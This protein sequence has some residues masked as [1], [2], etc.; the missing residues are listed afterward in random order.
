[1]PAVQNMCPPDI[2]FQQDGASPHDARQVREFL[3]DVF[4]DAWIGRRSSNEWPAKSCDMTP[5]D[6]SVWGISRD[7]VYLNGPKP[8]IQTLKDYV[9]DVPDLV[10]VPVLLFLDAKKLQHET[11]TSFIFSI[12]FPR[13]KCCIA[14]TIHNPKEQRRNNRQDV[15]KFQLHPF[16]AVSAVFGQYGDR[17]RYL[18]GEVRASLPLY[19]FMELVV[20]KL[21]VILLLVNQ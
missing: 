12:F 5:L 10:I 17:E 2:M 4:S 6:F 3:D 9:K 15:V 21:V 18:A 19:T 20:F 1:M 11:S 14:G 8:D 13:R 7:L 16:P